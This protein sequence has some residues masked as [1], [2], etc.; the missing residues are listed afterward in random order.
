MKPIYMLVDTDYDDE[1]EIVLVGHNIM[2]FKE[3]AF[4]RLQVYNK[5]EWDRYSIRKYSSVT[6][7]NEFYLNSNIFEHN[8][9]KWFSNFMSVGNEDKSY[10]EFKKFHKDI[11]TEYKRI[12]KIKNELIK[13]KFLE[14]D[15]KEYERLK[16]IFKEEK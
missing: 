2:D 1:E 13:K 6:L 3:F 7:Y 4:N 12:T 11:Y 16:K 15:R 5:Y 14:Q 8:N 9:D 10:E